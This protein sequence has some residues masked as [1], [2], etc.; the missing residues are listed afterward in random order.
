MGTTWVCSYRTH[1]HMTEKKK[2]ERGDYLWH[3]IAQYAAFPNFTVAGGCLHTTTLLSR[4]PQ[5]I[6]LISCDAFFV[7]ETRGDLWVLHIALQ[8]AM[9][10]NPRLPKDI[11]LP[12]WA[13]IWKQDFVRILACCQPLSSHV[14][15]NVSY[16][17]LKTG[18]SF[19]FTTFQRSRKKTLL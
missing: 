19:V 15:Y 6:W 10:S 2:K 16:L 14:S 1:R 5:E 9:A 18:A 11:H 13:V 8:S 17:Q 7:A 3:R 4:L 12:S